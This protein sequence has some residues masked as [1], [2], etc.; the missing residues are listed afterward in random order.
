M[1]LEE[2][3]NTKSKKNSECLPT[4]LKWDD[5]RVGNITKN[6]PSY[7]NKVMVPTKTQ[8]TYLY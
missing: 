5:L 2:K 8:K 3:N 7:E 4:N 1:K 6:K